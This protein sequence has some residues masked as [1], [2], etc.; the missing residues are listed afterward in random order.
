MSRESPKEKLIAELLEQ[1]RISGTQDNAFDNVAADRL[2][3]NRTD[4]ACLDVITRVGPVTAGEVAAAAGLTTGAVTAVV[5]RLERAGYARRV[6]DDADRRRV[7]IE[8]TPAFF[9]RAESIWRPI[10]ADWQRMIRRYTAKEL[11]LM[12]EMMRA[13]NEIEA[14]HIERIRAE[15]DRPPE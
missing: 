10:G 12:L 4:L 7:M 14:R 13:G 15:S 6:R 8:A 3:V 1:F 2:G 9:R 11:A 5:D